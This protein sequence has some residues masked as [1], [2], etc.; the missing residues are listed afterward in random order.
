MATFDNRRVSSQWATVLNAARAAGVHFRLNSGQRT[1]AEQERL[2]AA[3]LAGRGALA[4][5]PSHTAPHIRTGRPD[6]ALDVDMYVGDGVQG[7]A[8]WLRAKGAS[9]AWTVP[10]EGWHIEVP[11]AHL[12]RL[13]LALAKPAGPASWLTEVELRRVRE[14]DAIRRGGKPAHD[15]REEVLVRVLVE[16]R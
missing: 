16:Q 5:V 14:L 10:G 4:A 15:R 9:V 12:E 6:H 3:Y 7:L 11:R 1:F 8:R 2:R 13:M